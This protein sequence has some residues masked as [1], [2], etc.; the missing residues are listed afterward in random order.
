MQNLYAGTIK[1]PQDQAT[2]QTGIDSSSSGDTVLVAPGTYYE[3]IN[4]KGKNIVLG[5]LFL[6]TEDTSYISQ[7]VIDGNQQ[8]C[9]V[10]FESGEDLTT[11]LTG[12]TITNGYSYQD[13][14]R[15]GGI[16]CINS[17]NPKLNNLIITNNE[18]V[19]EDNVYCGGG[20]YIENSSVEIYNS[21]IKQNVAKSRASKGGGIYAYSSDIIIKYC[22]IS[23][24]SAD[25]TLDIPNSHGGGLYAAE[26]KLI[27]KNSTF[28]HNKS[29]GSG[30]G[31]KAIHSNLSIFTTT[32]A[33]NSCNP[34]GS[35]GGIKSDSSLYLE[36]V[37]ILNNNAGG[38]GGGLYYYPKEPVE[39]LK[40]VIIKNN[41]ARYG[42]GL[43]TN[44]NLQILEFADCS[45]FKNKAVRDG[46]DIH[47]TM[48]NYDTQN[49]FYL[50]TVTAS[51]PDNFLIKPIQNI[52]FH[53]KHAIYQTVD[54]DLF[55]SP[56]GSDA[57]K[58]ITKEEPLK[59]IDF[60]LMVA[61]ADSN[62]HRIINLAPGTYSLSE[63][64]EDFPLY[65]KNY[66]S[67]K[68]A[69]ANQTILDG[70]NKTRLLESFFCTNI[71]MEGFTIQEGYDKS[72]GGGL[73]LSGT[74]ILLNNLIIKDNYAE[75]I[76]G[77]L[78]I[79]SSNHVKLLNLTN[80]F[81]VRI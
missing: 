44:Q 76:G 34:Y 53:Y 32:I 17:S 55:V 41:K 54:L 35:G 49:I 2:I 30:G 1:V 36:D 14:L 3:N 38:Y 50:D 18:V 12:F 56:E 11:V 16:T 24:N 65:A 66:T 7:T 67:I 72:E 10:V 59:T 52:E 63:T 5:S 47:V 74:E 33:N 6:T 13:S 23:Y 68:G 70:D 48:L 40:N 69:G 71:T 46:A 37:K 58:G 28:F 51:A 79:Y 29:E 60:A 57:N 73:Y 26:C 22:E 39:I 25:E 8:G 45:I 27:V 62:N 4:F 77:G 21:I 78:S 81:S 19:G 64:G 42:G 43:A 15:G 75:L 9:V 61:S 80:A 31:I 20:I